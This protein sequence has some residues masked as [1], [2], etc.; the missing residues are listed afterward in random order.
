MYFFF[1]FFLYDIILILKQNLFL[2]IL[3]LYAHLI[4]I[5]Y[6]LSFTNQNKVEF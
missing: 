5:Q 3:V 1:I 2:L 4:F 6:K